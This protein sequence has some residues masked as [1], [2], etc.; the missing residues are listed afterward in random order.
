MNRLVSLPLAL[1]LTVAWTASPARAGWSILAR[2]A[3]VMNNARSRHVAAVL[4]DGKVL[5]A[6]GLSFQIFP[7]PR[8]G[9]T[10]AAEVYDGDTDT[11]TLLEARMVS[12][13]WDHAAAALPD[14]RVL[15]A[16]G[17]VTFESKAGRGTRTT[18]LFDPVSRRFAPG[19]DMGS[20]RLE[21]TATVL[22]DGRVVLVG[23]S[24]AD[25]FDPRTGGFGQF[26]RLRQRRSAHAALAI[27]GS[28]VL[29]VGG[30]GAGGGSA[31]IVNVDTALSFGL[32][33]RLDPPVNDFVL[34]ALDFGDAV[35]LAGQGPDGQ[36]IARLQRV[37][38]VGGVRDAAYVAVLPN[39]LP[40]RQGA[41]DMVAHQFGPL[42]LLAGGEAEVRNTDI[43]LGQAWLFDTRC[44]LVT[45]VADLVYPRDDLAAAPLPPNALGWDRLLLIG[46]LTNDKDLG[47]LPQ[48][49]CE[50]LTLVP[51][52]SMPPL[53]TLCNSGVGNIPRAA[54]RPQ[55]FP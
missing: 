32:A 29:V 41:S 24:S 47:E 14:G 2:R 26:V 17:K 34:A 18:E 10:D 21:L 40:A 11:W 35:A 15:L 42:V 4:P 52:D 36:T 8:A 31:E 38:L 25:V 7:L 5:A 28:R 23:G 43:I 3:A 19:P 54:D 1:V 13:R 6:G 51:D 45:A 48:S 12:P 55:E 37:R 44:Q 22:D 9:V 33:A 53:E 46:G 50:I 27:G 39:S 20:A 49:T 16:G 30:D